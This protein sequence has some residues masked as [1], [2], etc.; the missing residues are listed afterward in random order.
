ML[1]TILWPEG[2]LASF[3]S[4][5]TA[6]LSL[7]P[8]E[9]GCTC[10]CRLRHER[11]HASGEALRSRPA[12]H[13]RHWDIP[14]EPWESARPRRPGDFHFIDGRLSAHG[15]RSRAFGSPL[16]ARSP[17]P[18]PVQ[19]HT[20]MAHPHDR[21]LLFTHTAF[22]SPQRDYP[23]ERLPHRHSILLQRG[24]PEGERLII[25][26]PLS[27]ERLSQAETWYPAERM[28]GGTHAAARRVEYD[29]HPV[30]SYRPADNHTARRDRPQ[31]LPLDR[32]PYWPLSPDAPPHTKSLLQGARGATPPRGRE[33]RAPALSRAPR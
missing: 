7:P 15:E 1:A 3:R 29:H 6:V 5:V 21:S 4:A 25:R 31:E 2:A 23:D 10:L 9:V 14:Y 19:R 26:R 13:D 24:R 22:L 33:P 32:D 12:P 16:P 27:P 8:Y 11:G 30:P 18:P 17:P 28:N 20:V